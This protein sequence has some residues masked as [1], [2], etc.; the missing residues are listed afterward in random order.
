MFE[1][2]LLLLAP[3][4]PADVPKTYYI[5][6]VSAEVAYIAM[7]PETPIDTRVERKDCKVC[8]GSGLVKSGDGQGFT[9]CSNCKPPV[10]SLMN[11]PRAKTPPSMQLQVRPLPGNCGG[12]PCQIPR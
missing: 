9:K 7:Q 11:A 4:A 6:V 8:G 12:G 2:L 5:G 10:E 1:S 3:V